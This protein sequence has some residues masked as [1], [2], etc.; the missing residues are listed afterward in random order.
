MPWILS[1]G[2]LYGA[3]LVTVS[4]QVLLLASLTY[5]CI[6]CVFLYLPIPK[7]IIIIIIIVIIIIII[8]I[9]IIK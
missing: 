5:Y 7:T 4:H 6:L 3:V 9:I 1:Q 2:Q 8:I